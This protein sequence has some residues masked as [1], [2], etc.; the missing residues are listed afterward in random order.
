[1]TRDDAVI[2][3][4]TTDQ[5][6]PSAKD[7]TM[8]EPTIDDETTDARD[9][10]TDET[11]DAAERTTTDA[12]AT[13]EAET[14][15]ETADGVEAG[16]E[17]DEAFD[18]ISIVFDD[19]AD[20]GIDYD[21]A[22]DDEADDGAAVTDGVADDETPAAVPATDDVVEA[23]A[24]RVNETLALATATTDD[25]AETSDGAEA[26]HDAEPAEPAEQTT[27]T[28]AHSPEAA[29]STATPAAP[30]VEPTLRL[31]ARLD[32]ELR[33]RGNVNDMLRDYPALA[34]AKVTVADHKTGRNIIDRVS[35]EF[36]AGHIHAIRVRGNDERIALMSVV[37]G[38]MRPTDGAVMN[39]SLNVL[40]IEPG[41]LLAHRIG[42]IPQRYAVR[43]DLNAEQNLLYA[44]DASGR[45]FLKPKPVYARELLQRVGFDSQ[46]PNAPLAK[47]P[48]VE[49]RLVAV[50]RAISCDAEVIVADE[51]TGG[52]DADD[53]V[54]VLRALMA[55]THGDP[56][57]CVVIVT[58]DDEVAEIAETVTYLSE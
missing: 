58:A 6:D 44:M 32:A 29:T 25:D 19:I 20:A 30:G 7:Q 38:M 56:K 23:N 34:L 41:E 2:D 9:A 45:T 35:A 24:A 49:R 51:P 40:E 26:E 42:V 8:S 28:D 18:A 4:T 37:T 43:D 53:A 54:V 12:D 5:T 16:V 48:A 33:Q 22:A 36:R 55:L 39:K 13:T 14:A 17:A 1:M 57:R 10:A 27:G 21:I 47:L 50:A 3:G 31:S 15:D 11:T 52:L 46:T